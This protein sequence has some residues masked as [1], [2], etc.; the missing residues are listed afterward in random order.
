MLVDELTPIR[1]TEHGDSLSTCVALWLSAPVSRFVPIRGWLGR[2]A[3]T[4][5]VGAADLI[6]NFTLP[7]VTNSVFRNFGFVA[8]K[9]LLHVDC[10]CVLHVGCKC[11]LHVAPDIRESLFREV[12]RV[13]VLHVCPETWD[14]LGLEAFFAVSEDGSVAKDDEDSATLG[15][16]SSDKAGDEG[17]T[18]EDKD[19]LNKCCFI[20]LLSTTLSSRQ[21]LTCVCTGT[22]CI[23]QTVTKSSARSSACSRSSCTAIFSRVKCSLSDF[24]AAIS[25]C[26]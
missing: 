2:T 14:S 6:L 16:A 10:K 18:V 22:A 25:S 21:R 8:C 5:S 13:T 17:G 4:R 12:S 19:E 11:V 23:F 26:S 1:R 24:S 3:A 9:F 15:V 7:V 20:V